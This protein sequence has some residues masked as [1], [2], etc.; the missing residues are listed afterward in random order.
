MRPW[1][2]IAPWTTHQSMSGAAGIT[3]TSNFGLERLH[4]TFKLPMNMRLHGGYDIWGV[5][6]IDGGG[7]VYG[8][9]NPGFWLTGDYETVSFNVG[10]FKLSDHNWGTMDDINN[11]EGKNSRPRSIRR[12]HDF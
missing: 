4:G 6:V 12:L 2:L 10:Y 1:S 3:E 5:D 7:L 8:D 9:D 11:L